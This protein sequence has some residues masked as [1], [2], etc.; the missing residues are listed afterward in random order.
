MTFLPNPAKIRKCLVQQ[1]GKSVSLDAAVAFI[2]R[3]WAD[4]IGTFSCPIRVVCWLSSTNTNP[5]AVEQ[6]MSRENICVHQLPAMHAKVYILKGERTRCIVGSANLSSAALSEENASGQYEAGISVRDRSR[7]NSIRSWFE[8]LW[9]EARPISLSDLES[10]K[11]QWELARTK[12]KNSGKG[13]ANAGTS[14]EVGSAFPVNWQPKRE[15][16]D[17]ANEVRKEDFSNFDKY[18]GTLSRIVEKGRRRDVKELIGFVAEWTSHEGKYRPAL[19]EPRGRILKAFK[20]LFDNS[21]SIESR[22]RDLDSDGICK[23]QGFGLASLTMILHWR[24]PTEYPPFNRRTQ[25][26]L[27]DF[28]FDEYIPK[29]LNP[30]Q[31]GKWTAFAQEL[32]A[33]LQLPSTGHVDR[34]VWKYT[35]GRQV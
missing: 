21:R 4:I 35:E 16:S 33:R 13:K 19:N 17:L 32:S 12:K 30:T 7:V 15:L 2:G 28:G 22:L 11:K 8:G 23:I 10:A 1:L 25:L 20:V 3:D 24:V 5:Y 34:L 27:K 14:Q 29:T 9:D 18:T 31:F 26:F 6:M